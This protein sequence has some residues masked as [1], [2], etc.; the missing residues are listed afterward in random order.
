MARAG[1][2]MNLIGIAMIALFVSVVMP[3]VWGPR[4]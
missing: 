2:W 1:I 3:W 4:G